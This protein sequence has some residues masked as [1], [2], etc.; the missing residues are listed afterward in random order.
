MSDNTYINNP[1][2][3][4]LQQDWRTHALEF[5]PFLA[6]GAG[7]AIGSTATWLASKPV[8]YNLGRMTLGSEIGGRS[9]DLASNLFTGNTWG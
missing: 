9:V 6:I 5:A 1:I 3:K 2:N 4:G 7:P 8:L